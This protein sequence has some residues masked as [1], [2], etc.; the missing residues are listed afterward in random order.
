MPSK[1]EK[2]NDFYK[3][4]NLAKMNHKGKV[5]KHQ[6]LYNLYRTPKK[7]KGKEMPKTLGIPAGN[8]YQ[9]DIL[10]MPEDKKY[11]YVLVVV[12][13]GSGITDAEPMKELNSSATLEAIKNIF[14]RGILKTPEYKIQSDMGKEFYGDFLKYFNDHGIIIRYAKAGRSRSQSFVE[15]RNKQIAQALFMR[16][17]GQ[18]LIT[19]ETSRDWV[20]DLPDVI[21]TINENVKKQKNPKLTNRLNI[22]KNTVML[23]IG[24]KVRVALDKPRDVLGFRENG[25]NF[26]ATDTRWDPKIKTITNIIFQPDEP[27][28]YE[29]DNKEYPAYTYNQLQVVDEDKEQDPPADKVLRG[30]VDNMYINIKKITDKRK[31]QGKIQYKILYK[32]YPEAEWV[33]YSDLNDL[34]DKK[35][36]KMIQEYNTTH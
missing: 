15:A 9:T 11:K 23:D 7:D 16:M 4:F 3:K 6:E 19:G 21:K 27:I 30:D 20:D 25:Y 14:S 36:R 28:M 31:H 29:V 33:Y 5:L 12:D 26:R 18:E 32:G 34:D 24:T 35:I 22:N 17:T 13:V 2:I 1:A 10:Y 8:V